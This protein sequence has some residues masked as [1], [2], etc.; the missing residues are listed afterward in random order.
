MFCYLRI[1]QYKTKHS[2]MTVLYNFCSSI[3]YLKGTMN[4]NFNLKSNS[5]L[6]DSVCLATDLYAFIDALMLPLKLYFFNVC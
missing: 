4:L 3:E 6:T 5:L 1:K 2:R